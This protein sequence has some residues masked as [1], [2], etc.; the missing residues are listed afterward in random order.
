MFTFLKGSQKIN[1]QT[2]K[3]SDSAMKEINTGVGSFFK[4]IKKDCSEKGTFEF[5]SE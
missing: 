3:V 1:K 2:S 4:E 5:K